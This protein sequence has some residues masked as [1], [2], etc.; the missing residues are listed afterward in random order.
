MKGSKY[1]LFIFFSIICSCKSGTMLFG[2]RSLHDQYGQ[3]LTD[4]GLANTSMGR[5]WFSSANLALK[6]PQTVSLPYKEAGYFPADRPRAAGLLFSAKRG[7]K[8]LF[9]LTR[10]PSSFRIYTDLWKADGENGPSLIESVDTASSNFNYEA[11]HDVILLLR[12]QPELLES[13]DYTL[14]IAI[15]PSLA[16]PVPDKI[17]KMGSF[18]G[19]PRDGGGRRHEGIDI[20]APKG[21]PAIAAADGTVTSVTENRLGGKVVFM[22][23]DGSDYSLYYAHLGRQLVSA[24]QTVR[25]GDTLGTIDNTGNAKTTPSH[26]HF[27]IY[28]TGGAVDPFPFVDPVIRQPA[29]IAAT[30]LLAD[31]LRLRATYKEKNRV[32]SANTVCYS[33][34]VS[35]KNVRVELPDGSIGILPISEIAPATTIKSVRLQNDTYLYDAPIPAAPK[36]ELLRAS[37]AVVIKGYFGKYVLVNP[38]DGP[39]GWIPAETIY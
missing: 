16:F 7:Q 14:T 11:D 33:L 25:A 37:A 12:L 4:A 31:T 9:T 22:N 13:G 36:K 19:D 23:P 29:D 3:R 21:T 15:G 35:S 39:A 1:G 30:E 8:L 5:Q 38:G 27:G 10:N 28:T 6:K 20:F 2:K 18:W 17:G 26:L 34:A 32:L 24:G